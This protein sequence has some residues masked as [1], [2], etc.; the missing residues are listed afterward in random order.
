MILHVHH[1]LPI[2]IEA[3]GDEFSR[4]HPRRMQMVDILSARTDS[5]LSVLYLCID[6]MY[7]FTFSSY[8]VSCVV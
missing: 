3:A 2:D 8:N 7:S 5:L 4:H 6:F 1:D